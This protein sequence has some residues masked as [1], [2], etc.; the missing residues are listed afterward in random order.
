MD[1]VIVILEAVLIWFV[2]FV[3]FTLFAERLKKPKKHKAD[4]VS[5]ENYEHFLKTGDRRFLYE[6]DYKKRGYNDFD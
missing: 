3:V 5:Q 2:V 6:K 1:Y 4:W